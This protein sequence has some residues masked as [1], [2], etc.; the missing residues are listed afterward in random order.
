M[1]VWKVFLGGSLKRKS[2]I[3]LIVEAVDVSSTSLSQRLMFFLFESTPP[4]KAAHLVAWNIQP[5][6]PR[7]H[8]TSADQKRERDSRLLSAP[9]L[10]V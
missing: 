4:R 5:M 3:L 2:H 1:F 8:L 9:L 6:A 10:K 7:P